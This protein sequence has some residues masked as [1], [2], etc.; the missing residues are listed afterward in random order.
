[1]H[2]L[3]SYEPI[4]YV[5]TDDVEGDGVPCIQ[6]IKNREWIFIWNNNLSGLVGR[7]ALF[8]QVEKS[9]GRLGQAL[10]GLAVEN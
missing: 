8:T 5:F 10:S 3:N 1:M 6:Q 7:V 2:T 4:A 9:D